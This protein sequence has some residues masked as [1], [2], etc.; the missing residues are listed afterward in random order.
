M[1][2]ER[3]ADPWWL[4]LERVRGGIDR[5]GLER[6][7]GETLLDIL[8]VPQRHRTAGTYPHLERLWPNS[9]RQQYGS[10][11]RRLAQS[12]SKRS[13]L[14]LYRLVLLVSPWRLKSFGVRPMQ[15]AENDWNR[16]GPCSW[17]AVAQI[18]GDQL[19]MRD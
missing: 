4:R 14:K 17:K 7:S 1:A 19:P 15:S 12:T 3:A 13:P 10:H 9:D 8:E 18:D 2:A 6:V 11:P 5:D 16:A